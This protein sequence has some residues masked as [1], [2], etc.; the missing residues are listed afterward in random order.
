MLFC[1]TAV[2]RNKFFPNREDAMAF[3][4]GIEGNV[5]IREGNL[6]DV[7]VELTNRKVDMSDSKNSHGHVH[8]HSTAHGHS[9]S[10]GQGRGH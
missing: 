4:A 7:F 2:N 6:E 3:A 9:Q 1:S 10:H 8:G 5:L